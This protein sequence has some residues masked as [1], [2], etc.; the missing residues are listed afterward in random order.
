[1]FLNEILRGQLK[2]HLLDCLRRL[3]W[4][5]KTIS[6]FPSFSI[7]PAKRMSPKFDDV[8][9]KKVTEVLIVLKSLTS[10]F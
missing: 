2:L 6:S 7:V 5:F 4:V 10:I 3:I 1:M 9:Q 8:T